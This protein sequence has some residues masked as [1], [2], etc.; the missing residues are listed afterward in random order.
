MN[1]TMEMIEQDPTCDPYYDPPDWKPPRWRVLCSFFWESIAKPPGER[2]YVNKLDRD[3]LFYLMLSYMIKSLDQKN[4]SNAYVSGMKQALHPTAKNTIISLHC[5]IADI[6]SAPFLLRCLSVWISGLSWF[7]LPN[8]LFGYF[9]IPDFPTTSRALWLTTRDKEYSIRRMQEIGKKVYITDAGNYMN[10]WLAAEI[11]SVQMINIL[12]TIAILSDLTLWRWQ[13]AIASLIPHVFGNL[14]LAIWN[15]PFGL[16]FAANIVPFTILSSVDISLQ[17]VTQFGTACTLGFP[18]VAFPGSKAP[19]YPWGYWAAFG[20]AVA[21]II[22]IYTCYF[23]VMWDVKR[24][25]LVRNKFGL[26]VDRE[27]FTR[28]AREI[29][30]GDFLE[31]TYEVGSID[32]E[33]DSDLMESKKE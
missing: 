6:S 30:G 29:K 2:R 33:R 27:D 23:A 3:L 22:G 18:V 31:N 11:Y 19:H 32:I 12:P 20:T 24:R 26:Y 7:S 9:A 4:V 28:Q 14:V 5:L 25:G 8:A 21:N 17:L 1:V 15:E 10:L 13:L 16:K